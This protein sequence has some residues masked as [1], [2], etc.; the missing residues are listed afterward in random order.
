MTTV[1][2]LLNHIIVRAEQHYKVQCLKDFVTASRET[3]VTRKC[4]NKKR[5]V[6]KAS[7][8]RVIS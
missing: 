2:I 5:D 4:A 6:S 8:Y 7:V 3:C 1:G